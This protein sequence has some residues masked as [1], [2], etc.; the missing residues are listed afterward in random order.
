MSRKLGKKKA[1]KV[2]LKKIAEGSLKDG[3]GK[4]KF[5]ETKDGMILATAMA[6]VAGDSSDESSPVDSDALAKTGKMKEPSPEQLWKTL[7]GK[8]VPKA[9]KDAGESRRLASKKKNAP[10]DDTDPKEREENPDLPNSS[11]DPCV[12]DR[13]QLLPE[14]EK[15]LLVLPVG[16]S[17]L[18]FSPVRLLSD[19]CQSISR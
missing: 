3:E 8:K 16:Q 14:C 9:L 6:K 5:Y 15:S 7:T 10:S 12:L 11:C 2:E 17:K 1:K 4:I 13:Q 19:G 18:R